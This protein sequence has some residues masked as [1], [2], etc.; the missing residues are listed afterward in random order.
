MAGGSGAWLGYSGRMFTTSAP[1][2]GAS[3]ST[4]A[5]KPF[6]RSVSPSVARSNWGESTDTLAQSIRSRMAGVT[7]NRKEREILALIEPIAGEQLTQLIA[8]VGLTRLLDKFQG[9]E[10]RRLI[11]HL[12]LNLPNVGRVGLLDAVAADRRLRRRLAV[13]MRGAATGA[14]LEGSAAELI[15]ELSQVED[16][17]PDVHEKMPEYEH[18]RLVDYISRRGRGDEV[19]AAMNA[20]GVDV[21]GGRVVGPWDLNEANERDLVR[22]YGDGRGVLLPYGGFNPDAEPLILVHG[23]WGSPTEMRSIIES[24]LGDASKQVYLFFY[25]DRRNSLEHSSER[26][27]AQLAGLAERLARDQFGNPKRGEAAKKPTIQIIAHSMGGIVSKAAINTMTEPG[28]FDQE[29]KELG[30]REPTIDRYASVA[31]TAIDTPW[32]GGAPGIGTDSV[33]GGVPRRTAFID[34]YNKS[35]F[36]QQLHSVPVADNVAIRHLEAAKNKKRGFNTRG[37]LDLGDKGDEKKKVRLEFV[38]DF[39]VNEEAYISIDPVTGREV[40]NSDRLGI[41]PKVSRSLV[42]QLLAL[43]SSQAYPELKAAV[44]PDMSLEALEALLRAQLP[45]LPGTHGST[46]HEPETIAELRW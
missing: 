22:R 39:M 30:P 44:T 21:P 8:E 27:A 28:W 35:P 43:R 25:A 17:D 34:M 10:L 11:Y 33:F 24:Y 19:D 18:A 4:P 23:F 26:L 13:A 20:L 15:E 29:P 40:F 2:R 1:D 37:M 5:S 16:K 9:R 41:D 38:R 46:L 14:G 36:M 45:E 6:R 3:R 31:L 42:N 7:G 32:T 12:A